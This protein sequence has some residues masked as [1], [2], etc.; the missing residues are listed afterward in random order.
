LMENYKMPVS[1]NNGDTQY[2]DTSII[3]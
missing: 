3:I 1:K 2:R